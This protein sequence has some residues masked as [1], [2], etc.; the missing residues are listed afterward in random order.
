MAEIFV[1]LM[2]NNVRVGTYSFSLLVLPSSAR[3]NSKIEHNGGRQAERA[4]LA[5]ENPMPYHRDAFLSTSRRRVP[6]TASGLQR[7]E[8][9]L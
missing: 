4:P 1:L 6:L 5:V 7:G 8:P 2:V 9:I 3:I